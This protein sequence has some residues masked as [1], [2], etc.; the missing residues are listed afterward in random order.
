MERASTAL[1]E[2]T[3]QAGFVVAPTVKQSKVK[4]IELVPLGV[5]KVLCVLIANEEMIASHIVE[6]DEPMTR[7]EATA[8]V[9]FINTEL[10]GLP[11]N[12]LLDLLERRMLA[13]RDSLY[14]LIKRSWDIL[15][16]ALSTEPSERLFMEGASYVVSQP[17]FSRDPQKAQG[18][19]R[20]LDAEHQLLERICQDMLEDG[21]H[22]RIGHEVQLPGLDDC[23]YIAAPFNVGD[24]LVGGAV[25]VLGPRR[26]DY[27]R[28]RAT[29]EAMARCVT[30]SVRRWEQD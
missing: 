23:S 19:L 12:A 15:Q 21:V 7:D 1:S 20:G 25:G 13:E 24:S 10:V 16:H 8:L 4:Q 11:Y 17:E 18:L 14:Y 2:L 9:R 22:V 29:V 30:D 27:P 26:M 5:R 3:Q 6:I 28:I